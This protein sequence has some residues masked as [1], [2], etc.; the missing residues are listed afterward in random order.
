MNKSSVS[1]VSTPSASGDPLHIQNEQKMIEFIE[2]C[3]RQ[4][5]ERTERMIAIFNSFE[6]RIS[7]LEKN[8]S[9]IH[10]DNSV[11]QT[12]HKNLENS[13]GS[14]EEV[15]EIFQRGAVVEKRIKEGIDSSRSDLDTYLAAL[16]KII[17][18]MSFL[19]KNRNFKSSEQA[20]GQLKALRQVA[21]SQCQQAFN[22]ALIQHAILIDP[23]VL[24][25]ALS[26][27]STGA[28]DGASDQLDTIEL[29]KEGGLEELRMTVS[30]FDQC[31]H[32]D[33]LK[34][35]QERRSRFLSG[36]LRKLAPESTAK[37]DGSKKGNHPFIN[38][39]RAFLKLVKSERAFATSLLPARHV[40]SVFAGL[41]GSSVEMLLETGETIIKLKRGLV[42]PLNS[43]F[44]LIDIGAAFKTYQGEFH[45]V[46]SGD[47]AELKQ[48][49]KLIDELAGKFSTNALNYFEEFE[50]YVKNDTKPIAPDATVHELTS[51]VCVFLKRLFDFKDRID[52]LWGKDTKAI[53]IGNFMM[54]ILPELSANIASKALREKKPL[55]VNIFLLNNYFYI[56]K[57]IRNS[58]LWSMLSPANQKLFLEEYERNIQEQRDVYK[59][60]WK[61]TIKNLDID[62]SHVSKDPNKKWSSKEKKAI[63]SKFSNFNE[64]LM[65]AYNTQKNFVISDVDLRKSL[66]S[67]ALR[68]FEGYG[69]FYNTYSN[70]PFSKKREKY[71]KFPKETVREMIGKLFDSQ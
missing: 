11:L 42:P 66:V 18:A 19:Q 16:D 9:D 32:V 30:R 55:L 8:I 37:D 34:E 21:L 57:T 35:Y 39:I 62:P 51:N 25:G 52:I 40:E 26:V 14:V 60:T 48:Q 41:I 54:R 33:Y 36:A 43:V 13:I 44:A 29:F 63:K 61:S 68:L 15:L 31:N 56:Q 27:N 7:T 65:Q 3:L 38:F 46:L 59:S 4:Q 71:V 53:S 20:L 67:D 24:K 70:V 22:N 58:E 17:E 69:P 1:I 47:N 10:T 49:V 23:A 28:G 12:I 50:A 6:N 64:E 2:S 45:S 5:Q